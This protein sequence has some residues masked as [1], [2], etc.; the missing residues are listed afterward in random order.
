MSSKAKEVDIAAFS[1]G[2]DEANRREQ[3]DFDGLLGRRKETQEVAQDGTK[4]LASPLLN[5]IRSTLLNFLLDR[6]SEGKLR[7]LLSER[8][9]STNEPGDHFHR[10]TPV[11]DSGEILALDLLGMINS[12]L[13]CKGDRF[14]TIFLGAAG[15]R[16]TNL[17]TANRRSRPARNPDAD[18]WIA[19]KLRVNSKAKTGELWER[20]PEW[21]KESTRRAGFNKRVTAKRKLRR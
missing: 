16:D 21:L 1:A 20:A 4:E 10:V 11:V 7:S 18:A 8:E 19:R 6:Y 13:R 17:R 3:G 15:K 9:P 14:L 2:V 12:A 5:D